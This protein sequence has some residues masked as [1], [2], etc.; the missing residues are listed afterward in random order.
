MTRYSGA[1]EAA[2][3]LNPGGERVL[4]LLNKSDKEEPVTV[5]EAGCGTETVLMPHS[6]HTIC[7]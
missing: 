7:Y 4:V 3:F 5:R 1:V 6:I 2:A